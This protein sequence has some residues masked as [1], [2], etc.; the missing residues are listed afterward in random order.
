[1][2]DILWLHGS[3]SELEEE[4][5]VKMKDSVWEGGSK[6]DEETTQGSLCGFAGR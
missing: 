6:D 1:M 4:E 5:V 3:R 2:D